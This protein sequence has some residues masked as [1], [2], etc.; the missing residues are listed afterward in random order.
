MLRHKDI[1]GTVCVGKHGN[2]A[3]PTWKGASVSERRKL[4]QDE[5]RK[6]E[7][8]SRYVKAVEMGS[9]GSWTKWDTKQGKLSWNN[10]WAS[11]SWQLKFL[12]RSIYDVLP[13]PTNYANRV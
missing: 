5:I 13:T 10:I 7:E 11:T 6:K 1:V 4:V 9:Q 2:Y 3:T 8:E 12:L